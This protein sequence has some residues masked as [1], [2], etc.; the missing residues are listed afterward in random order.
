LTDTPWHAE[1]SIERLIVHDHCY[2]FGTKAHIKLHT[3]ALFCA[4]DEGGEA[5]L[6]ER[7]IVGSAMCEEKRALE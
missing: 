2:P 7:C 5:V 3:I 6:T 4:C 1:E